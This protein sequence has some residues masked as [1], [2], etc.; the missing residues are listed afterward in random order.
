MQTYTTKIIT[1]IDK[2]ENFIQ[3]WKALWETAENANT[4]NSYEW[5]LATKK[6]FSTNHYEIFACYD[7]TS[8]IAVLPFFFEKRFGIP[9]SSSQGYKPVNTPFLMKHYTEEVFKAFFGEIIKKRNIYLAKVDQDAVAILHKIFPQMFFSLISANPYL[10]R[11][12]NPSLF[13]STTN[14]KNARRIIKK[15]GDDLTYRTYDNRDELLKYLKLIFDVEQRSQKKLRNMDIFSN[16][17]TRNFFINIVTHCGRFIQIN[18]LSYK[19][20][21]IAYTF[22]F[23]YR[24]MFTGYQTSFLSE[25]KKFYPGKVILVH[26]LEHLRDSQFDIFN[27]GGGVSYYKLEFAPTFFF[28]YDLYFSKNPFLMLWWKAI[29]IARRMKQILFPIKHTR[30]HEFLF[31]PLI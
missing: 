11:H 9:V 6:T 18:V 21:P 27:L 4:F 3:E 25:Y 17:Q 12:E 2:G 13:L 29:N 14:H 5:F 19:N 26:D 10:D 23:K 20:N 15:L 1:D 30:D 31:K 8:L 16:E 24:N 7:N 22:N 28:L